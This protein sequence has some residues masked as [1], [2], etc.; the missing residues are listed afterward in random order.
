MHK[1]CVDSGIKS[2]T[3]F[4]QIFNYFSSTFLVLFL[5]VS[6]IPHIV[7]WWI[8]W[9]LPYIILVIFVLDSGIEQYDAFNDNST[10][11]PIHTNTYNGGIILYL[12]ADLND[13]NRR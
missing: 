2:L 4:T 3:L 6:I 8:V 1:F 12:N 13:L 5:E 10:L 7:W 11:E 9:G